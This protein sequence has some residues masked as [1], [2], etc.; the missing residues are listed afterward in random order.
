MTPLGTPRA[1]GWQVGIRSSCFWV[2]GLWYRAQSLW[3]SFEVLVQAMARFESRVGFQGE[4]ICAGWAGGIGSGLRVR[5][6]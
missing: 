3:T 5:V 1:G 2:E 4:G 6:Y